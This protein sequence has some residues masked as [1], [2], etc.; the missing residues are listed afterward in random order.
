[1]IMSVNVNLSLKLNCVPMHLS[2][3]ALRNHHSTLSAAPAENA[4]STQYTGI[5]ATR[6]TVAVVLVD[7]QWLAR[8]RSAAFPSRVTFITMRLIHTQQTV[9]YRRQSSTSSPTRWQHVSNLTS[10]CCAAYSSR[11]ALRRSCCTEPVLLTL[12]LCMIVAQLK[13]TCTL[14][15]QCNRCDD[16]S[17]QL[18][19]C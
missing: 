19:C 4:N 13:H 6:C 18:E 10:C 16:T 1:M 2:L 9:N 15:L 17:L 7:D 11:M 3:L 5:L 14:T 8:H 12:K